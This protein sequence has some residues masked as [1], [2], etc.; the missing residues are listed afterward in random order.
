MPTLFKQ[1]NA[2]CHVQT[3]QAGVDKAASRT[4]PI[5]G[6]LVQVNLDRIW[7]AY[8]SHSGAVEEPARDI[9]PSLEPLCKTIRQSLLGL[10]R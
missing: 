3:E 9:F 6:S 8:T 2:N 1:Q 7:F 10:F 5:K 4:C